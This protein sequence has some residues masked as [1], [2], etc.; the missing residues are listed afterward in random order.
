MSRKLQPKGNQKSFTIEEG[1]RVKVVVS[2]KYDTFTKQR[3]YVAID[4]LA[5]C[6]RY[7]RSVPENV[8][9]DIDL[10][11]LDLQLKLDDVGLHKCS[12][13]EFRPTVTEAIE[14]FNKTRTD[15]KAGTLLKD[16]QFNTHI[17]EFL[18]NN[19]QV[20]L[21]KP[22]D[23]AELKDWML[24]RVSKDNF[25]R[26]V[27]YIK[28]FFRYLI[29]MKYISDSP[30]KHLKGGRGPKNKRF[31]HV[32]S[33]EY[34]QLL[35]GCTNAKERLIITFCYVAGIRCPSELCGMRWSE[36]DWDG[37]TFLIHSPKTEHIEG[38]DERRFPL[39]PELEIR[40]REYRDTLPE[41]YDDLMFQKQ[42][43][44]PP[45]IFMTRSLTSW[46]EKV[47][48][49]AG[50]DLWKMPFQNFRKT[51]DKELRE[52]Y[53]AYKVN[54]W[55]GHSELTA[56]RHYTSVAAN[57]YI[58]AYNSE[59][60]LTTPDSGKSGDIIGDIRGDIRDNPVICALYKKAKDFVAECER[61]NNIFII[62]MGGLFATIFNS[63]LFFRDSNTA[64]S[65]ETARAKIV[66]KIDVLTINGTK[67]LPLTQDISNYINRPGRT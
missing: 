46:I 7:G 59:K 64:Y 58:D 55:M 18:Y 50:V 54:Y 2:K 66:E 13:K 35:K 37:K 32:T 52:K 49:R 42:T 4:R 57:D 29:A 44:I 62:V 36:I 16:R 9:A 40:L 23:F 5:D 56:E 26:F 10:L 51:R 67:M 28:M 60:L 24:K 45:S 38:K 22:S 63:V 21:I 12:L 20:H 41:G 33:E 25:D 43:D 65:R 31:H 11:P 1:K 3:F 34:R 47:A 48:K 15:L 27:R 17:K 39:F 53:P 61:L 8:L 19:P 6:K 30:V 14:E